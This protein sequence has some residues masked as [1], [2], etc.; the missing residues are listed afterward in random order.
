MPATMITLRDS[1]T[2]LPTDLKEY[3]ATLF[4]TGDL[5]KKKK[6]EEVQKICKSSSNIIKNAEVIE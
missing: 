3:A 2:R 6:S 4:I 1:D 5:K